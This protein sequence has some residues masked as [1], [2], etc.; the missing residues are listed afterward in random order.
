MLLRKRNGHILEK[1]PIDIKMGSKCSTSI[2]VSPIL[3]AQGNVSFFVGIER[4]IIEERKRQEF[5]ENHAHEL[6]VANIQIRTEKERAEGI[7]RFLES[8]GESVY[9]TDAERKIIFINKTAAEYVGKSQESI[10]GTH[11]SEHFIFEVGN[12]NDSDRQLPIRMVPETH[13]TFVFPNH[14]FVVKDGIRLPITGT[15]PRFFD[16]QKQF[17]GVIIIFQDI[18]EKYA[19]EQMKDRFLSVAGS[20]TPYPYWEYALEYGTVKEREFW[21]N[22]GGSNPDP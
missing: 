3:N 9:V 2:S 5:I 10:V 19:L 1:L 22:V 12:E 15:A 16:E 11:T 20:S 8:I 14:M 17:L 13:E 21:G 7:L 18:T 6:E 4:D